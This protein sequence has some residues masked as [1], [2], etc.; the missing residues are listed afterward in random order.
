VLSF[1]EAFGRINGNATADIAVS[2][3]LNDP[4]PEG[5]LQLSDVNMS[6]ASLAQPFHNV[7]ARIDVKGRS[8]K[9]EKLTA[10]DRGGKLSVQGFA[11]LNK[12]FSGG[13]GLYLEASRFPL[14]Q[15]G[16]IV[17]ELTM[18]ARV[19]AKIPSDLKAQAQ[20]KILDG[21]IWLTGDRGK[22]VQTLDAHPDIRFADEK[23][24][25]ETE[26]EQTAEGHPGLV[27]GLFTIKTE[28]D[29]WLEH[30]DFSLQVGVDIKL[31]QDASGPKLLGQ[32][33]LDRGELKL[34]G[35]SFKLKDG[36]IKFTGDMPPDPELD[37]KATF[38]PPQGQDLVVQ[39]A[40]RGSA[41][42]VEFSGAATTA[43]EAVAVLTGKT[44]G[45]TQS[46]GSADTDATSQM[47]GLASNMTAGLLVMSARRRF[48]D[49]VPMISINTG[50]SG[51]PTGASAGFDASKLI[52]PWAKGFARSAYV[53]G[54]IGQQTAGQ[55]GGSVGLGVK[56]EVALPRDF[57][58][59]LGY[60]PGSSWSTD[61]AWAP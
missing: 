7:D 41:P 34:L 44:G 27:L 17:G 3:K 38:S 31:A 11:T 53:E 6:V 35:K 30:E 16:T 43:G 51:E 15:Q 23:T 20:L 28:S 50:T 26:A 58:T 45:A 24:D 32:A 18:R 21:R 12:D 48:G 42:I 59:D 14:R 54:M 52:P 33:T 60:G 19:D 49:W 36:S 4:Y 61:V 57:V 13:G 46:K 10:R 47:A 8:V 25:S 40:G 22:N 2:G 56:L 39:V 55:S 37:I 29:L 1:T 9:L 5:Y